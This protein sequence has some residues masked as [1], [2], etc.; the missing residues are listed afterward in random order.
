MSNVSIFNTLLENVETLPLD[1]QE[2]F[3][4][5][6]HQRITAHKRKALSRTIASARAENASGK[7]KPE[8]PEEI[9]QAIMS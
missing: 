9:L 7:L 6:I 4:N 3:L 5:I 8:T 2:T 1:D